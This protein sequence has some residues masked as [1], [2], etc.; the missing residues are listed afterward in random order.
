MQSETAWFVDLCVPCAPRRMCARE[1]LRAAR[2]A[3]GVVQR[4]WSACFGI[5]VEGAGKSDRTS[6]HY[7]PS[8]SSPEIPSFP[9]SLELTAQTVYLKSLTV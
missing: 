9:P 1:W 3:Y 6:G 8:P 7:T 2:E 4:P 5:G